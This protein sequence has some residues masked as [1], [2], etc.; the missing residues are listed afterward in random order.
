MIAAVVSYSLYVF[1]SLESNL[2]LAQMCSEGTVVGFVCLF[3]RKLTC[4]KFIHST[5][6]IAHNK[7]VKVCGIFSETAPL[8]SQSPSSIVRLL[9]K[10]AISPST[11]KRVCIL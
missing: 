11:D 3:V 1:V 6:D 4:G 10:S 8:Q 5:N 7:G 2:P 9:H